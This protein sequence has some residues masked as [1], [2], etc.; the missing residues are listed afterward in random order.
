MRGRVRWAPRRKNGHP[1]QDIFN[2]VQRHDGLIH[3]AALSKTQGC[4]AVND[5]AQYR[6]PN[7]SLN[8]DWLRGEET[9]NSLERWLVDN[10]R[11]KRP[12]HRYTFETFGLSKDDL[13]T[14]FADYRERFILT[15]R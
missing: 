11:E 1:A 7:H 2:Q 10:A 6:K 9:R 14:R 13:L 4:K 8:V 3:G 15:R 12:P 5:D